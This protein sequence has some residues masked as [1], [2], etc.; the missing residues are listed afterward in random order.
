MKDELK[1]VYMVEWKDV[2]KVEWKYKEDLYCV[3][4]KRQMYKNMILV[5]GVSVCIMCLQYTA[6]V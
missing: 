2:R 4:S 5:Y 3:Y 6:S 1:D